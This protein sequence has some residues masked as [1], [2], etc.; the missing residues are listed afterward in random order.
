MKLELIQHGKKYT[1]EMDDEDQSLDEMCELFKQLLLCSGYSFS[2][3]VV[4]DEPDK[5]DNLQG[6]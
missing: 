2:G 1:I 3:E 6:D 5:G 4:I